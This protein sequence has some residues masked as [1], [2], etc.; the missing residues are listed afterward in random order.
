MVVETI[1]RPNILDALFPPWNDADI[2]ADKVDPKGAWE[3]M[4]DGLC[5][6]HAPGLPL[7]TSEWTW[8]PWA[9]SA[10]RNKYSVMHPSAESPGQQSLEAS[11]AASTAMHPRAHNLPSPHSDLT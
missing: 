11:V 5:Q 1:D 7:A 9:R 4:R 8:A 2:A 10:L 6:H 3:G